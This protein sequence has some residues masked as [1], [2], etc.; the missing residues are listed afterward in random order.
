M[1]PKEYAPK[2]QVA[3]NVCTA[4]ILAMPTLLFISPSPSI[5]LLI[6]APLSLHGPHFPFQF[7]VIYPFLSLGPELTFL[8]SDPRKWGG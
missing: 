6:I 1:T 4:T 8:S 7:T 2:A 5:L 3:S